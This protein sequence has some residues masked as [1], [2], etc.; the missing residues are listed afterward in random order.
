ME[1][2]EGAMDTRIVVT[3]EAMMAREVVDL[4]TNQ[5]STL[6]IMGVVPCKDIGVVTVVTVVWTTY[7]VWDIGRM[8][9]L[10]PLPAH[11]VGAHTTT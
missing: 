3:L 9:V 11:Y 1:D 4:D 2:R 7:M 6:V 10:H 8:T 5:I